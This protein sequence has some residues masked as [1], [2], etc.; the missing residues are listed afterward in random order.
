MNC[1]NFRKILIK[2]ESIKSVTQSVRIKVIQWALTLPWRLSNILSDRN[3]QAMRNQGFK[4]KWDH[5]GQES[6]K[7]TGWRSIFKQGEL[8]RLRNL[9]ITLRRTTVCFWAVLQTLNKQQNE[10]RD[11]GSAKSRLVW[12]Q[13]ELKGSY[14]KVF[15]D[16]LIRGRNTKVDL[17][18]YLSKLIGSVSQKWCNSI[19]ILRHMTFMLWCWVRSTFI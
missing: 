19:N 5:R 6:Y 14:F 3:F 4:M 12:W 16:K 2:I 11:D 15:S 9:N 8:V 17:G 10:S 1:L 13:R 18:T 7:K